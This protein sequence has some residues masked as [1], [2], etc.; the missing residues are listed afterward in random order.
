[1]MDEDELDALTHE[2]SELIKKRSGQVVDLY[3]LNDALVTLLSDVG[4]EILDEAA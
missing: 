3:E 2:V 4:I 1:M